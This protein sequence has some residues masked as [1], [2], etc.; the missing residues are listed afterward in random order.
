MLYYRLFNQAHLHQTLQYPHKNDTSIM[1]S[2][3]GGDEHVES[4]G[5]D[6][7]STEYPGDDRRCFALGNM[8]NNRG[9]HFSQLSQRVITISWH[10]RCL[11]RKHSS[12]SFIHSENIER[13]ILFIY[14]ANSWKESLTI[15]FFTRKGLC[16][17]SVKEKYPC[18]VQIW[19][20]G[21]RHVLVQ[22]ALCSRTLSP[23][24]PIGPPPRAAFSRQA[25]LIFHQQRSIN[26]RLH[27]A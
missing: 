23:L 24:A 26:S 14:E 22:T 19:A 4:R 3:S 21:S 6:N 8:H 9:S 2:G 18:R 7:S 20:L 11:W 27:V 15:I 5:Q 12:T 13:T 25:N 16:Y 10:L 17:A 1:H